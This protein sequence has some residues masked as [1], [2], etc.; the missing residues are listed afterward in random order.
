MP[1]YCFSNEDG[2]VVE[3]FY[4]MGDAPKK[5]TLGGV[6]YLRDFTAEGV[7]VPAKTCWP[8]TCYASGVHPDQAQTLRD[9]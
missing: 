9:H 3:K 6:V 1:H 2:E 8:R 5:I 4:K 7:G